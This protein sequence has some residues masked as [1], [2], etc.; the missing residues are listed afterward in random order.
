MEQSFSLVCYH[1]KCLIRDHV[2]EKVDSIADFDGY[3]LRYVSGDVNKA[4]QWYKISDFLA[5]RI[6]LKQEPLISASIEGKMTHFWGR[7][8]PVKDLDQDTILKIIAKDHL[9]EVGFI[10]DYH[11]TSN[12][13]PPEDLQKP[14]KKKSK[15]KKR[16]PR[17]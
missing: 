7:T 9:R 2:R 10:V 8:S 17:L 5:D 11:Q 1:R 3:K 12:K 4:Y 6:F 15:T 16:R 14:N 13:Q